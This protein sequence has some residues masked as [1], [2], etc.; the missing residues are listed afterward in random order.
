MWVLHTHW[1]PPKRQADS[2][3]VLFWAEDLAALTALPAP[4]DHAVVKTP[5]H[6]FCVP[7]EALRQRLGEGTPL[8]EAQPATAVLHL[9]SDDQ[10]PWPSPTLHPLYEMDQASTPR[11][12][13]WQVT[14][15]TLPLAKAFTIL[16]TLPAEGVA[17]VFRLGADTRYWQVVCNLVLEILAQQKYLPTL[18]PPDGPR[19]HY[20]ARWLPVLDG[21][22]DAQRLDRLEQAMPPLCR[23]ERRPHPRGRPFFPSPR[24]LLDD[25]IRYATDALVR[26]W[27]RSQMPL[28]P[29]DS[30]QVQDRWLEALFRPDPMVRASLAQV[31]ALHSTLQ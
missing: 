16:T 30:D 10:R 29:P 11:L 20:L 28:I 1:R 27:G 12:R 14:G 5:S 3:E 26:T 18:Q 22:N 6:P 15:L 24:A 4:D 9:P 13:Q 21:P 7:P 31:R 17:G 8:S 25:F 2:G 19:G 23:A